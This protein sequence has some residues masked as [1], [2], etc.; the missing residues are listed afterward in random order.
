MNKKNATPWPTKAVMQQIYDQHLWGGNGYDFY[1]GEGSHNLRIITPYLEG[2]ITF[3]KSHEKPLVVCDLGCGDFNV[4]QHFT[5]YT[6]T[7]IGIDI[8]DA[9]I[10]RN[11]I[12]FKEQGLNFYCLDATKD[13]LPVA[14]CVIV[15]QVLQHLSNNEIETILKKLSAYKYIILTEHVPVGEFVSNKDIL[16]GQGIRLKYNS[17]VTISEPPFNFKFKHEKRLEDVFLKNNKGR[18]ATVIYQTY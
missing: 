2:I 10:E 11:K 5:K 14:D 1:S 17:G 12:L 18:I 16:T 3:L 13:D 8:V 7:Y 6:K 15:R 9:L 4:G